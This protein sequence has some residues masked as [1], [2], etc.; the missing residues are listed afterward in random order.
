MPIARAV[1]GVLEGRIAAA[2]A[3]TISIGSGWLPAAAAL[4]RIA[5]YFQPARLAARPP[6][7]TSSATDQ[8][9]SMSDSVSSNL[10][11]LSASSGSGSCVTGQNAT[12]SRLA[13]R[14]TPSGRVYRIAR[15]YSAFSGPTE[16]RLATLAPRFAEQLKADFPEIEATARTVQSVR[17]RTGA[18]AAPA[19]MVLIAINAV[20]YMITAALGGGINLL[21]HMFNISGPVRFDAHVDFAG[22]ADRDVVDEAELAVHASDRGHLRHRRLEPSRS[23]RRAPALGARP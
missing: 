20:V 19:T 3:V 12:S 22:S 5:A 1:C 15:D 17:R 8:Q 18:V 23:A 10:D 9:V 16:L 4:S 7:V 21:G 2:A 14:R 11:V 6:M 13:G